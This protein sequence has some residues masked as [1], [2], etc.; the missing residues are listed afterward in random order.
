VRALRNGVT[1]ANVHTERFPTGEIR[2]K[3]HP[4]AP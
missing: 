2:S 4:P 3:I 1:Y